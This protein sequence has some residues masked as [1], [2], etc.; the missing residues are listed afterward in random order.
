MSEI[1]VGELSM[2]SEDQPSS[3]EMTEEEFKLHNWLAWKARC[4]AARIRIQ[5]NYGDCNLGRHYPPELPAWENEKLSDDV[6]QQEWTSAQIIE[7]NKRMQTF[8]QAAILLASSHEHAR[9]FDDI[10][11]DYLGDSKQLGQFRKIS[12]EHNH[13]PFE[14]QHDYSKGILNA[15]VGNTIIHV[16]ETLDSEATTRSQ[17]LFI[18]AIDLM[19]MDVQR[20]YA[21]DKPR[22]ESLDNPEMH[23]NEII[24]LTSQTLQGMNTYL[25]VADD[26]P[27]KPYV[28]EL[29]ENQAAELQPKLV[30]SANNGWQYKPQG[31]SEYRK[32]H[33][34]EQLDQERGLLWALGRSVGYAVTDRGAILQP[35][36]HP[37]ITQ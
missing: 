8:S 34:I 32:L 31:Y 17:K 7:M 27:L 28:R 24:P 4:D 15:F 23:F 12:P 22:I 37:E 20:L 14:V 16:R 29:F 35:F 11:C 2:P 10:K 13:T 18:V 25:Q 9:F 33:S 3:L 6:R 30:K 36:S 19:A 5:D 26:N 1:A 21:D